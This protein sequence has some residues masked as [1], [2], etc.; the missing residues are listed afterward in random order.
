MMQYIATTATLS[1]ITFA[2]G[3]SLNPCGSKT[4]ENVT[5]VT[6]TEVETTKQGTIPEVC[7]GDKCFQFDE[8]GAMIPEALLSKQ[9]INTQLEAQYG[10]PAGLLAA[11]HQEETSGNCNAISH[12]GAQGCFQF[13]PKTQQYI[14][15]KFGYAFNPYDY[16]QSAKGAAIYLSYLEGK[17]SNWSIRPQD[18]WHWVLASYN[19]GATNAYKFA[20]QGKITFPETRK[21]VYGIIAEL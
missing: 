6:K 1:A 13:M 20:Q 21:Y 5:N 18:K 7:L 3:Y 19:A 2:I 14:A 15:D 17:V 12:V 16:E 9:E 10:L 4:C 8:N 11:I